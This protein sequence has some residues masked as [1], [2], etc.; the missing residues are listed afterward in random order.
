MYVKQSPDST[1]FI[2]KR[3]S[4]LILQ[5]LGTFSTCSAL[6]WPHESSTSCL[7]EYHNVQHIGS[8]FVARLTWSASSLIPSA[9]ITESVSTRGSIEAPRWS[10]PGADSLK[11]HRSSW[12]KALFTSDTAHVANMI[13]LPPASAAWTRDEIAPHR[14]KCRIIRTSRWTSGHIFWRK[15]FALS[16]GASMLRKKRTEDRPPVRRTTVLINLRTRAPRTCENFPDSRFVQLTAPIRL[17]YRRL[18][19]KVIDIA[20]RRSA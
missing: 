6:K 1:S 5:V 14:R 17:T 12:P 16:M 8:L 7:I 18:G 20:S 4:F 15:S 9:A 13:P 2:A 11:S 3:L 10:A 19:H